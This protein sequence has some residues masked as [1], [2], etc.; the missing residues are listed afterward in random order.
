MFLKRSRR[1]AVLVAGA[2]LLPH[3][4][5]Q[6]GGKA[7]A[8]YL[9]TAYDSY[10]A[11]L[12]SSPYRGVAWQPLGPTNISGRAT[13]IAVAEKNGA[14]RIYAAY[15]TSGVWK[16]DDNGASWQAVF[17]HHAV[18]EHRRC[19]RRA[20]ESGHRVG[21]HRRGEPVPRVHGRHWRL[22]V[23]RRRHDV[24]PLRTHRHADDRAHRRPPVESRHGL[25][26]GIRSRVDRQRDARRVQD[27]RRRTHVAEGLLSQPAHWRDRPRDGSRGPEHALR[28]DVAARPAEMERSA[29][30]AWLRGGR[31]L[32]DDRCREDLERGERGAARRAV[33]RPDRTRRL[34]LEP[35]RCLRLCRQLRV[36]EGRPEKA[37]ATPIRVRS[38][39][40]ASSPRRFIGPTTRA[41]PGARSPRT[42]TS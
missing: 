37:S 36:R 32:E 18:D 39:R 12:Q 3:L 34:A 42:T 9:R 17:E 38:S 33:P 16:T 11:M 21:R 15:A 10:R 25:R 6:Q 5:A 4:R 14:R 28:R 31:D 24:H 19:R 41:G 20:L 30:G 2:L 29:H 22:Q 23:H 26:R 8:E 27:D 1:S 13:D 40:R 35:E 7:D